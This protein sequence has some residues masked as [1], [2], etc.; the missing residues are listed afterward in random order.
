[1][2]QNTAKFQP[3]FERDDCAA[4]VSGSIP[5]NCVSAADRTAWSLSR[6]DIESN[7]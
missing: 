1:M 3:D 7:T 6:Q 4:N 5:A 2:C